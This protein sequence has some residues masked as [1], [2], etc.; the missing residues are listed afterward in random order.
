[1]K[2]TGVEDIGAQKITPARLAGL[3][4]LVENKTIN[5]NTAR[6]VL[7]DMFASGADAESIVV[8]KGLGQVNDSDALRRVVDDVLNAN[9]REVTQYLA[10]S[11]K[12][13]GFFVGQ[14]MK[15]LKGKGNAR[16]I[17]AMLREALEARR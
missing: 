16:M 17:N 10:G 2:T 4:K 6:A 14:A 1:M 9:S 11:D 8:A 3:V 5:I 12:V 7:G 15:A 13:F